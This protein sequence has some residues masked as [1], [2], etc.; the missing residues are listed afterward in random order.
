MTRTTNANT[1][2][3][4]IIVVLLVLA[5]GYYVT[6]PSPETAQIS[7]PAPAPAVDQTSTGSI[8]R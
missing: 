7:P 3:G 6:G 4:A 1:V 8:N 5:A 2:L